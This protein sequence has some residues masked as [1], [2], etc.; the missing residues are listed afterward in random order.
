M[1]VVILKGGILAAA[2]MET[3]LVGSPAELVSALD[4]APADLVGV[5]ALRFRMLGNEKYAPYRAEWA[6]ETDPELVR[7]LDAH[8]GA[9]RGIVSLHTGCICFDGWQGWLDLLA[10]GWVWGRRYHAPG[11]ETVDVTP[12]QDHPVT[13]DI[14]PFAVT[15]EHYGDLALHP[16]AIILAQGRMGEGVD[17]PVGWAR[18]G[19]DSGIV[20]V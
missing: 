4:R 7:A 17:H 5:Q 18:D 10:G 15:D 13:A 8:A 14:A 20:P 16:E 6:Y 9:G 2:G 3:E 19:G 1:R 11:L 12:V